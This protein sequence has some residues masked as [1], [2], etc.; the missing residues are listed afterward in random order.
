MAEATQRREG[1]ELERAEA[2]VAER[3]RE[4]K[5]ELGNVMTSDYFCE[6][7]PRFYE[8][9]EIKGCRAGQVMIHVT[10]KGMVR[11]ALLVQYRRNAAEPTIPRRGSGA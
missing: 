6:T 2:R 3:S 11:M 5:R 1:T 8:E 9:R 4:L 7:L 10:P